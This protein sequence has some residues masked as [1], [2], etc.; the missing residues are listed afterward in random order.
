M[1]ST[2]EHNSRQGLLT[3]T[4]F[5]RLVCLPAPTQQSYQQAN[6]SPKSIRQQGRDRRI[7]QWNTGKQTQ[8]YHTDTQVNKFGKMQNAFFTQPQEQSTSQN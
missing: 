3:S 1:Q 2:W 6:S 5:I 4:V 8:K 7:M